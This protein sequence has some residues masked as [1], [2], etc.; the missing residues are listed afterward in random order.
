MVFPEAPSPKYCGQGVWRA[1]MPRPKEITHCHMYMGERVKVGL[2]PVSQEEM[3]LFLVENRPDRDF[4]DPVDWL[5]R[6]R[7]LLAGFGDYVGSVREN[8]GPKSKILYRPLEALLLPL[9]W[10]RGRVVLI[11]D[12]AHATTPHRASGAGIGIEDALVL[13]DE[14]AR[15][16]PPAEALARFQT[17]RWER[18]RVV[19]ENSLRLGEIERAG[20]SEQEHAN[21]MRDSMITL[22]QPI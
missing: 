17:R 20:G 7:A 4:V 15:G 2:N 13:A 1:V 5:P 18:C 21:L 6:L 16:G 11:G 3:Y 19:V 8:L 22:A 14:L 10:S 12:A 9:P